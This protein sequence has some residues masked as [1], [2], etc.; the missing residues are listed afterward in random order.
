M[1]TKRQPWEFVGEP[2]LTW[3]QRQPILFC[4]SRAAS[5][6]M[7]EYAKRQVG[8]LWWH[9]QAHV[10][11][12]VGDAYGVDAAV[13]AALNFW[14]DNRA[15]EGG[16]IPFRVYGIAHHPRNGAPRSVYERVE[17]SGKTSAERYHKRDLYMAG[18]A[19]V[20]ICIWDGK[21]PGTRAVAAAAE[22]QGKIVHIWS[23]GK[24]LKSINFYKAT[25]NRAK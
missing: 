15:A 25:E 11:I 18:L 20:V 8:L 19:E 5:A 10:R 24:P 23:P 16:G 3:E 14:S 21:S 9:R 17:V 2:L 7:T 4:G 13:V 12:L 1:N 22:K 6:A